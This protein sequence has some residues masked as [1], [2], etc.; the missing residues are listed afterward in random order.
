MMNLDFQVSKSGTTNYEVENN[1]SQN[2]FFGECTLPTGSIL[3]E[4][5]GVLEMFF[6]DRNNQFF[7]NF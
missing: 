6:K 1:F 2:K 4:N 7:K 3:M 5:Y